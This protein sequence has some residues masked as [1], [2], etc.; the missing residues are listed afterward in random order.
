MVLLTIFTNSNPQT[1]YFDHPIE[2]PSYIRASL[3]LCT[4]RGII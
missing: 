2:K 3:H 4:I 1:L